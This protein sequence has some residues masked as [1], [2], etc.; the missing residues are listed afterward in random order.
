ML[1]GGEMCHAKAAALLK[2]IFFPKWYGG[3]IPPPPPAFIDKYK[4]LYSR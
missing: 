4:L 1:Y 3:Y 2:N